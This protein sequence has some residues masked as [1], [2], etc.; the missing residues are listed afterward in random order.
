M[1]LEPKRIA[2]FISVCVLS[3]ALTFAQVRDVYYQGDLARAAMAFDHGYVAV[4]DLKGRVDLFRR[5]E[6][7]C[8]A[9][10]STCRARLGQY[11]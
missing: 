4:Y 2:A 8:T 6:R 11:R 9:L 7:S 5:K 1:R 10:P 3:A